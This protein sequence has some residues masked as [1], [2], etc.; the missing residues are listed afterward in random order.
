MT[1][2]V[3][4]LDR[5]RQRMETFSEFNGAIVQIERFKAHDGHALDRG[6]LQRE[7][8]IVEGLDYSP[9]ALGCACSHIDLWRRVVESGTPATIAEDDAIFSP[10]FPTESKR[11]MASVD[12]DVI[13]WGVNFDAFVWTEIPQGIARAKLE[14][15][16]SDLRRN[17]AQYRGLTLASTLMP[18]KHAFGT[19]AYTINPVGARRM[20]DTC[21]PL[22]NEPIAF[23]GYDVII[24]NKG[25]DS[26]MNRVY[27][28]L[29]SFLAIPPLVVSENNHAT[30][31]TI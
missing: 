29:R 2:H 28:S 3:I 13:M 4:N 6:R 10:C 12:W 21:L 1:V 5:S 9:G 18:L 14:F 20:L 30:S 7:G 25:I 8:V 31:S 26:A 16:Q 27:P 11:L 15:D 22:G 24:G 17:I 19:M 23:H